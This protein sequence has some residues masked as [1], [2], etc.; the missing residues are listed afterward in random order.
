M[1]P[2]TPLFFDPSTLAY[3]RELKERYPSPD[4]ALAKIGV[5]NASLT[6]PKPSVHVISDV[7]GEDKKLRHVVNNASGSIRLLVRK[8]FSDRMS[9]A[10][11]LKLL[12]FIYYPRESYLYHTRDIESDATL[13][14][15]VTG[16]VKSILELIRNLAQRYP[17]QSV[18]DILPQQYLQLFRELILSPQFERDASYFDALLNPFF[19]HKKDLELLRFTARLV[20]NLAIAEL[21]VAGDLGDR[22]SRM[23]KVIEFLTKQPRV[24][25]TWGNHDVAWMG[26]CLGQD[27]CI[28]SV[29]RLSL[30][31]GRI[32]QLEEG[33]GIPLTPLEDLANS[34]YANDP[35]E[36]YQCKFSGGRDPA[37][38]ARMQKAIAIIQFKLESQT[39]ARNPH[40]ALSER[41]LISRVKLPEATVEIGGKSHPLRDPH[42]PTLNPN[43]PSELTKEEMRCILA[44]KESFLSSPVLWG[45]MRF[46]ARCGKM[47]LRRDQALIFHGCVPVNEQGEPLTFSID[48]VPRKGRDLFNAIELAVQRGFQSKLQ[49][50]LDLL[51]YLWGGPLSPVF[52]KDKI[53]TF[54]SY[55]IED[56]ETHHEEKNPYF[57]LIHEREFCASIMKEFGL[58]PAQGLIVNGH[59]PVKLEKG[60]SPLKRS[61][62]AVTID[63]AFSEAYG[64]KGYTLVL[65]AERTYL[66]LHNHFESVED[67]IQNG[68]DMVPEISDLKHYDK[69]RRVSDTE[70]GEAIHEQIALLELLVKA[71]RENRL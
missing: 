36:R 53:A 43:T 50:D 70:A 58:D 65:E 19:V 21:V 59:V 15:L 30:R 4:T 1:H 46:V 16:M 66:A 24:S 42:L 47:Y 12:S 32:T 13:R 7:H 20:R 60:E 22:G 18:A 9:E 27:A 40:F 57:K 23:D 5:L 68:T 38:L 34:I 10:E 14:T 25:M 35:A 55:F 31:Y 11:Q 39:I 62:M 61:G 69:P 41:D 52:G 44:L 56:K 49:P 63:G 45:H 33:Y 26:A 48:G 29:I 54:E 17:L 71:Y 51:W 2:A 37:L 6:L 8:I 64:D 28:A 67:S 3:L